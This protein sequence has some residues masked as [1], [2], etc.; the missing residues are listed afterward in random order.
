MANKSKF[1]HSGPH[2]YERFNVGNKGW[3]VYKCILPDCPHFLSSPELVIGRETIC[4]SC[5]N[6]MIFTKQM[7]ADEI[8]APLC[9][10]CKE[11]KRKS[12]ELMD[13]L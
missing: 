10:D 6:K 7:C 4:K 11:V 3:V 9:E 1:P 13:S 8:K 5:D 2:K 12:K